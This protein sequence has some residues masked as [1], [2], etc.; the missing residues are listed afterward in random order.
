MGATVR[1]AREDLR[2]GGGGVDVSEW[3][4][5]DASEHDF[6][7]LDELIL[8]HPNHCFVLPGDRYELRN[9]VDLHGRDEW[10]RLAVVGG[11]SPTELVVA[12]GS[13][14][15]FARCGSFDSSGFDR[16]SLRNLELV[17][18]E[19][20]DADAGWGRWWVNESVDNRRLSI[21]GRRD[22]DDGG[23]GDKFS[24]YCCMTDPAGYGRHLLVDIPDGDTPYE[25]SQFDHAIGVG[26]E[27]PHVGTNEFVGGRVCEHWDNGYYVKDGRGS[28]ILRGCVALNCGGANIRIGTND[29][30]VGCTSRWDLTEDDEYGPSEVPNGVCLDADAGGSALVDGI[31]VVKDTGENDAVR[32]RTGAQVE[33]RGLSVTNRTG[34]H[35]IRV[36]GTGSSTARLVGAKVLDFGGASAKG[37]AVRVER[38]NTALVDCTVDASG[39]GG[40]RDA[41]GTAGGAEVKVRGGKYSGAGRHCFRVHQ[42]T[43]LLHLDGAKLEDGVHLYGDGPDVS[44]LTMVGN[45]MFLAD[46]SFPGADPA[47]AVSVYTAASN[48]D[49]PADTGG[50]SGNW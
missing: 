1:V 16:L 32:L 33:Y 19:H 21:R 14:D 5:V 6:D 8:E 29:R 26:V 28:N 17:L 30:V 40:D 23:G 18:D 20:D 7:G 25:D 42:G 47:D 3:P 50:G 37:A 46:E 38:R 35:A 27:T 24:Y 12:D 36:A 31:D 22:Y 45:D 13:V 49:G 43:E 10:H 41:V 11:G 48:P 4:T 15:Y 9:H 2:A 44:V 34:Q 39:G